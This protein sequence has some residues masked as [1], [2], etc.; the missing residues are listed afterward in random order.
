MHTQKEFWPI[1]TH[2]ANDLSA[3][4]YPKQCLI[5]DLEEGPYF[6]DCILL[7]PLT[8][9]DGEYVE[10]GERQGGGRVMLYS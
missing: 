1:R 8:V 2:S 6:N 10:K 3:E 9:S 4:D 7:W 5:K